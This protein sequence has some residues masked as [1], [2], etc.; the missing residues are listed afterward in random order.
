[1]NTAACVYAKVPTQ[2][3]G[4]QEAGNKHAGRKLTERRAV[5][6]KFLFIAMK[7]N[8]IRLMT[9]GLNSRKMFKQHVQNAGGGK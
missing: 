7:G 3:E 4:A 1:V 8:I 6:C 5:R 9:Y 2:I